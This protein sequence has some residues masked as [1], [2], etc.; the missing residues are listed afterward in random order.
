MDTDGLEE[1]DVDHNVK[2]LKLE[3]D[4]DYKKIQTEWAK[5][6]MQFLADR[7]VEAEKA[8]KQAEQKKKVQ[9]AQKAQR[10]AKQQ[11]NSQKPAT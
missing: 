7:K 2:Q 1:D 9:E 6:S 10:A 5:K 3:T 11:A 8:M 4:E